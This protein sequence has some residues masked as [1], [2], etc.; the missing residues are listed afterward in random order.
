M[1]GVDCPGDPARLSRSRRAEPQVQW[2]WPQWL[3]VSQGRRDSRSTLRR[4]LGVR[5]PRGQRP[6]LPPGRHGVHNLQFP[7]RGGPPPGGPAAKGVAQRPPRPAVS[8]LQPA[9]ASAGGDTSPREGAGVI[10][11]LS[12][13]TRFLGPL[14]RAGRRRRR[15]RGRLPERRESEGRPGAQVSPEAAGCGHGRA[16][17]PAPLTSAPLSRQGDGDDGGVIE[18]R[19]QSPRTEQGWGGCPNSQPRTQHSSVHLAQASQHF[20]A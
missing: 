13:H 6:R 14:G 20:R 7:S 3:A 11:S 5:L 8:R 9:R 10:A 1:G 4:R 17:T 18:D 12:L 2:R 16:P 15:R 19:G